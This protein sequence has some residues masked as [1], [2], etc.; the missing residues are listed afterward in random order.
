MSSAKALDAWTRYTGNR[1]AVPANIQRLDDRTPCI[2][3]GVR[4]DVP[5]K[6]RSAA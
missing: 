4:G 6:H 5:C 1:I 2:R 3:C